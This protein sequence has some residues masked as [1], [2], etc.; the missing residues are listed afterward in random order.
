MKVIKKSKMADGTKIQIEDWREDYSFEKTL[1][2]GVYPKAQNS[3]KNGYIEK[4]NEFRLSLTNFKND[5]QVE[6]T[7]GQLEK[8]QIR[9]GDLSDYFRNG[10][11]DKFYL[12]LSDS[13]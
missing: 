9:L 4:N 11:K 7:F 3:S 12:G 6:N 2:I 5:K 8:G 13:E 1:E 10:K